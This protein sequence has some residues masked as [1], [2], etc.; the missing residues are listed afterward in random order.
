MLMLM[1]CF[2]VWMVMWLA[3]WPSGRRSVL[4]GHWRYPTKL[5]L[6]KR[7]YPNIWPLLPKSLQMVDGQVLH[8]GQGGVI[9]IEVNCILIGHFIILGVLSSVVSWCIHHSFDFGPIH[10]SFHLNL[11]PFANLHF[12]QMPT[13]AS[14][15]NLLAL[16]SSC[17]KN[18][19]VEPQT[20]D[21]S[22]LKYCNFLSLRRSFPFLTPILLLSLVPPIIMMSLSL[23]CPCR[24]VRKWNTGSVFLYCSLIFC[25]S[26]WCMIEIVHDWNHYAWHTGETEGI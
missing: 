7:F 4:I 22:I 6:T 10:W 23:L 15:L 26:E 8:C 11:L 21:M 16:S 18:D 17:I 9:I 12:L 25:M 3:L 1:A 14:L 13:E 20:C 5:S 24:T 2:S 19:L